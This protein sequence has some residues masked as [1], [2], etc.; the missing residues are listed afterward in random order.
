MSILTYLLNFDESPSVS[1][2]QF[3]LEG[4]ER[5][6]DYLA[7]HVPIKEPGGRGGES[8]YKELVANVSSYYDMR[9]SLRIVELIPVTM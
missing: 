4:D 7:A 9:P 8:I 3:R 2:K 1:S 6:V 5:L